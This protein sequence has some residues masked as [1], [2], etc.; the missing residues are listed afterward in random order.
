[1]S[2]NG[3]GNR[4]GTVYGPPGSES[5]DPQ[6]VQTSTNLN[7]KQEAMAESDKQK[8]EEQAKIIRNLRRENEENTGETQKLSERLI[9][10]TEENKRVKSELQGLTGAN[11]ILATKI[12]ETMTSNTEITSRME[13]LQSKHEGLIKVSGLGLGFR[14]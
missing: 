6:D 13:D 8:I 12:A 5:R 11:T 2:V 3:Y 1:M 7:A 10:L 9:L 14:V 4:A